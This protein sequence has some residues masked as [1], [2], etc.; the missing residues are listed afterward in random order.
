LSNV[1]NSLPDFFSLTGNVK[2]PTGNPTTTSLIVRFA[3]TLHDD[4]KALTNVADIIRN[5][6]ITRNVNVGGTQQTVPVTAIQWNADYTE[7]TLTIPETTFTYGEKVLVSFVNVKD[8][9]E[10]RTLGGIMGMMMFD[11]QTPPP[12]TD[13]TP[14]ALFYVSN[15]LLTIGRNL[16]A[17]TNED[18]TLYLVPKATA[19][20]LAALDE[21]VKTNGVKI[22]V[23]AGVSTLLNTTGLAAGTYSLYAVDASQNVSAASRDITLM[24]ESAN[25]EGKL[26]FTVSFG[27]RELYPEPLDFTN[28]Q[29]IPITGLGSSHS[30]PVN[31]MASP[32]EDGV[33][34]DLSELDP[35]QATEFYA[36]IYTNGHLLIEKFTPADIGVGLVKNV[37]VDNQ[38][39]AIQTSIA[40]LTDTH[41]SDSINLHLVNESGKAIL[42]ARVS[43]GTKVPYGTYNIQFI[44]NRTNASYSLFKENFTV[45]AANSVLSFTEAELAAITIHMDSQND[46]SYVLDDVA[47]LYFLGGKYNTITSPKF[48]EGNTTLLVTKGYY[49]K[50]NPNYMISKNNEYWDITFFEENVDVQNDQTLTVKDDLAINV[51]WASH[52]LDRKM[53]FNQAFRN[54][55][56]TTVQNSLGQKVEW[57]YKVTKTQWGFY[58]RL[59]SVNGKVTIIANGREYS[60]VIN[61]FRF[62]DVTISEITGGEVLSGQVEIL[63]EV[64]DSPI[65]IAPYRERVVIEG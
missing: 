42:D 37:V 10:N 41:Y 31:T 32:L 33:R 36:L 5:S 53:S 38:Y 43:S 44:A 29:I 54:Y 63:F 51:S 7:L 11:N 23:T 58:N 13:I 6:Q 40:G 1:D 25:L 19:A 27:D 64:V 26:S 52:I 15:Q 34:F 16:S 56:S 20:N 46:A 62:G 39:A 3:G 21:A 2:L 48:Q 47:P 35:S 55:F 50:V 14:P 61:A 65:V 4:T 45:S 18:G 17:S 49:E 28:V 22:S 8:A 59:G 24:E 9:Y 30:I 12:P 60:K 57:F